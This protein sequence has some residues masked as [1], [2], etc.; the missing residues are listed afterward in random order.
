MKLNKIILECFAL[1]TAQVFLKITIFI[2]QISE[3]QINAFPT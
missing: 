2:L 3:G 1:T